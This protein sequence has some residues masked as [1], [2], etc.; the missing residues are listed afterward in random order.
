MQWSVA[1][2]TLSRAITHRRLAGAQIL[3]LTQSNPTSAGIQYPAVHSALGDPRSLHYEPTAAGLLSAREAVAAYYSG[4]VDPQ[5]ILLTASTSEAYSFL[6]KLLCNPYDEVLVPRPSYPLFDLLAQL[7]CVRVTQYPLRYHDGW[8][9]DV[10]VLRGMVSE[11]TRA[12]VCVNPNNPT[13]SYLKRSEYREI[14][15][16]CAAHGLALISDEVFADYVI[17]P[18]AESVQTLVREEQCLSFSLSGLSKVC[19]LPQMKLGWIVAT[20]PGH[21]QA[22]ERLEWIADTFLSVGTPVQLAVPVLLAARQSVQTQI[23]ERTAKNLA[24]LRATVTASSCRVLRVEGGWYATLQVPRV[25]S[26]EMWTLELLEH[27][28]LVQPGFFFDFESE[29]FL[30]L[31]LLTER[32]IFEDGTRHILEAC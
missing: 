24:F 26:E 11:R 8:F 9:V 31:S 2:N 7:E 15:G 17:E 23:R 12:I 3:D 19:G 5:R 29:A 1:P 18:D 10:D 27:G 32:S 21:Q 14:A 20:G 25:R 22:V 6:F 4:A 28:V 13:G 16:L 30:V